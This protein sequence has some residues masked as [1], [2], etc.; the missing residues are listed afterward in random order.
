MNAAV[1]CVLKRPWSVVCLL[2]AA[3]AAVHPGSCRQ[4][5]SEVAGEQ[6]LAMRVSMQ[7]RQPI[8]AA[9]AVRNYR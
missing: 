3:A 9:A 4:H 5:E 6:K 2:E 1:C 7:I 8:A